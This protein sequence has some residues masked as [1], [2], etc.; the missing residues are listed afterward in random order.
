M[1]YGATQRLVSR[2]AKV[3][4]E[5]LG[6]LGHGIAGGTTC[7][8]KEVDAK[9]DE[10]FVFYCKFSYVEAICDCEM[11]K[12]RANVICLQ[13]SAIF[14]PKIGPKGQGQPSGYRLTIYRFVVIV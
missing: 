3:E 12:H 7:P 5:E 4:E 6:V 14:Q 9:L 2:M 10:N 8:T 13:K 1:A 11:V